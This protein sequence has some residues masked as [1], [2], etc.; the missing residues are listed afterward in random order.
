MTLKQ[1]RDAHAK[2]PNDLDIAAQFAEKNYS[3]GKKKEA[4]ELV[5]KVLREKPRHATAAYVK[6]LTLIDDKRIEDAYAL[7][8][9]VAN[10]ELKDTKPLKLL[11]KMQYEGKKF[12]Q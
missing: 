11:A 6:A 10:D 7:L 3:I 8:D 12:T 9:S 1:L 5:D 4:K 2:D